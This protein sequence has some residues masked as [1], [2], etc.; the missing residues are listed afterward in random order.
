MKLFPVIDSNHE[1][2]FVYER[3]Q[4]LCTL[5]DVH[6][7]L[8]IYYDMLDANPNANPNPDDQDFNKISQVVH[9]PVSTITEIWKQQ[10]A[11]LVVVGIATSPMTPQ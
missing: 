1:A 9:L 10:L 7:V 3:C 2:D 4:D 6:R 8:N 5:G 11:Y